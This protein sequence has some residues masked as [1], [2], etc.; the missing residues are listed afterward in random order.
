VGTAVAFLAPAAVAQE[1]SEVTFSIDFQGPTISAPSTGGPLITAGDIL[2]PDGGKP[3]LANPQLSPPVVL[4]TGGQLGLST[5][6]SCLGTPS[7]DFC[8]IEVD[9]L[10]YGLD[11][12]LP[13]EVGSPYRILFSV[14]EWVV[15]NGNPGGGDPS[16]TSEGGQTADASAD[17]FTTRKDLGPGPISAQIFRSNLAL[18]DGNGAASLSGARYPGIGLKE[19]TSI[20]QGVPDAGDNIDALDVGITP[21][22]ST[23]PI[24]FSLDADFPDFK[25]GFNN[26]GTAI[27]QGF[28]GADV[29]VSIGGAG[30]FIY[31]PAT[32][33]GLDLG[34]KGT[35][36]LD[37]LILAENGT[38]GYQVSAQPYDWEGADPSDMLLFSVRRG[39]AVIGKLDSLQGIPI[40]EGDLLVPPPLGGS[41]GNPGVLI[42]AEAM[43]LST[44]R[45][46]GN[47]D[48]LS[49]GDSRGP[50]PLTDCN[51][52][53][54][55]DARDIATGFSSDN[56]MNGIPDDCEVPCE[57]P[58]IPC[59]I[60]CA[61]SSGSP[62]GNDDAGAGCV[63]STGAGALLWGTGTASWG[64]DDLVLTTSN[65]PS[66][67]FGLSFMSQ[68]F[69]SATA[70]GDGLRCVGGSIKRLGVQG[71]GA[72]GS[73]SIGPGLVSYTQSTPNPGDD[74]AIGETWHFQ[75]W[76][77]ESPGSSACGGGSNLANSWSLTFT[78]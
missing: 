51:N 20:D 44:S 46:G 57:P 12:V 30:P 48:D 69:G 73:F 23:H 66:N 67:K 49:A 2:G 74:I 47:S 39:S 38:A 3:Q 78:L 11:F 42:A 24:Y 76:F 60:T 22:L 40:E 32:S 28:H 17:V 56:N 14:D 45:S 19:P 59:A 7:Q 41:S 55:D 31:A 33:L 27:S 77:R 68:T 72:T 62:C 61:C 34:G 9:A 5:Y 54:Q 75:T 6:A 52:N 25:E 15:G 21:S 37:V 58:T 70:L 10:S 53:G 36:D 1:G 16:V 64:A 13:S 71:T 29:L 50:E 8:Q 26:T 65:M 4:R 63:N 18:I 43:G 35:D